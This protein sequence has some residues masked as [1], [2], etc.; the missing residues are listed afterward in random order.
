MKYKKLLQENV[1]WIYETYIKISLEK[2]LKY[3][4]ILL[5]IVY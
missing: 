3:T 1:W 2:E 5:Y 4:K